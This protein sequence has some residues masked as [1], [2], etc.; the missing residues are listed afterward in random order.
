MLSKCAN[1]ECI[2]R[3]RYLHDGK[4]FRIDI[5]SKTDNACIPAEYAKKAPHRTEFF[6]LCNSC[7]QQ[8]TLVY[9][10]G[11]GVITR[12]LALRVAVGL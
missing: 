3:F 9:R 2:A 10:P 4:L 8:V 1:P 12:P 11:V 7:S 5:P 6:W